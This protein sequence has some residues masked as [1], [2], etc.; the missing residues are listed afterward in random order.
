M[1]HSMVYFPWC[2][3]WYISHDAFHGIFS[4]Q[5]DAKN[6]RK[7]NIKVFNEILDSMEGLTFSTTWS[8]AQQMLLDNHRFTDDPDLQSE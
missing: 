5:E 6:L 8:E 2:I 7:R 4:V 1:M 3:P